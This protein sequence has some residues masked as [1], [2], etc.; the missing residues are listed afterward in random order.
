MSAKSSVIPPRKKLEKFVIAT[1]VKVKKAVKI[2]FFGVNKTPLPVRIEINV[3]RITTKPSYGTVNQS[4]DNLKDRVFLQ[5]KT[6]PFLTQFKSL[7]G[8]LHAI[9]CCRL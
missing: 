4:G 7:L 2:T 8:K 6:L 5:K 1:A 9:D 3:D